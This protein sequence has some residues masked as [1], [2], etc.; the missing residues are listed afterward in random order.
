MPDIRVEKCLYQYRDKQIPLLSGEF[1]YW[2]V[3]R[4]NWQIIVQRIK[5]M[6]LQTVA[7]YV[8]WNYHEIEPGVYDFT[9]KT[10]PQRDLQG[11]IDL[12]ADEGIW[13]NIRPGP[14][15]Y[16]EW[17]FGG[18]PERA[19]K[20]H[21]LAPEF[22]EMSK[23]YITHVCELIV[24]R[25][26]TRGGNIILVQADNEPY[27]PIESFGTEMGGFG[28]SGVFKDFLAERYKHDIARLNER[29]RSSYA[30]FDEACIHFHEAYVDVDRAM[31]DRLLPGDAY[32]GR[33][34][35]THAFVGWYAAKIVATVAG[36]L[37]DAGVEVPVYANGWSPLYQD[38]SQFMDIADLAGTDIYPPPFFGGNQPTADNWFYNIDIV[39]L[40]EADVAGG[41]TWSAEYQ[42]GIYPLQVTGYLPPQHYKFVDLTLMGR[43]LKGWNWYMLVNRDNWHNCPINEWGRTNEYYPVHQ[44]IVATAMRVEPWHTQELNDVS[45]LCYKPH[46]VI[47]PGNFE[48]TCRA[49]ERGDI[50]YD[51]YDPASG[52]PP[53]SQ[54]LLY[55]GADWIDRE[56]ARKL[57]DWV[58]QGGTLVAFNRYPKRDECGLALTDLLPFA[59]PDGA[60]PV[61]LPVEIGYRDGSDTLV[62]A[63]HMDIKLNL[64]YYRHV[65]GEPLHVT[66]SLAAR[67][68]LVDIGAAQ[69]ERFLIGYARPL[70]QGKIV[71]IGSNPSRTILQLVLNQEGLGQYVHATEP[72]LLSTIHRHR[73]GHLVLF[74]TNWSE[75][76]RTA[77]LRLNR[78]RLG[79]AGKALKVTDLVAN[80]TLRTLAPARP[81]SLPLRG[82]DVGVWRLETE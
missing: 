66:L 35:D 7:S 77:E 60:R 26:I 57:R 22:L 36:W 30:S 24:P 82:R 28:E 41:N 53:R 14:Y 62:D 4:E 59:D 54:V 52:N 6:G 68:E 3:L 25:Q 10:S 78:E 16:S 32:H 75:D 65:D 51:Y 34:A 1:H 46:R 20:H 11:F 27:P 37:R 18:V 12:L 61:N 49:L 50:A 45:V 47:A 69:A 67:E 70:G 5:E 58:E 19:S 39:K 64:F 56:A 79:L 15:I 38:F 33:Y 21:R 42:A 73:E 2:R 63:G 71:H 40:Q 31:A 76:G 48:H 29:W 13:L 17:Q 80:V 9:G 55:A 72:R 23:H 81:L 44:E 8:P 74:C 43:G